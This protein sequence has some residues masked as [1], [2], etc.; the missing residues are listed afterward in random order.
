RFSAPMVPLGDPRPALEVFDVECPEKG[1]ARWVDGREWAYDFARDLPAGVRCTFRLHAGLTTLDGTAVAGRHEFSFSTGGP[2]V[3]PSSLPRAGSE[4]IDE[5]Q[6]FL[7][8]LDAPVDQASMLAH[9]HFAIEGVQ[10]RVGARIVAGKDRESILASRGKSLPQGSIVILQARQRFPNG[11]RG[12]LVW[13]QGI[14]TA[15]GG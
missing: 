1:T 4:W 2:A 7:L 11:A 12:T 8:V 13:G 5:E 9:T 10:S 14:V 15:T 3:L 6:A